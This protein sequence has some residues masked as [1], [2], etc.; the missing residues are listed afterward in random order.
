[1]GP[2]ETLAATLHYVSESSG[3]AAET[4][5]QRT[6]FELRGRRGQL[7]GLLVLLHSG[8]RD[9][10]SPEFQAFTQRLTG[11]LA[12]AIETRQLIQAQRQLFD[13]VI[14]VLADA[15]DAKSAYT[16]GHCERVPK[17]SIM[18]ADRLA[19]ETS[20]PY[21]DFKL[22]E[23]D[24]YAFHLAAWL[25]DCG[26]VTSPEHIVDKA[27]KLE[28][29]YDRIHEI[30]MRF[31]V[32]WRDAEI[33]YLRALLAG[34]D[35]EA[36]ADARNERQAQLH[37]DFHFVATCNLGGEFLGDE[38]I[39]RLQQISKTTWLRQFDDSLG[40]GIEARR[41]LE[42]V[43]GPSPALPVQEPLLADRPEHRLPWH[44]RKPPVERNDPRNTLGFDM[45][46]PA[47]RQNLGELHNLSIRRGTLT[48]EDRFAIND[49]IVQTLTM[50]K[51]LPWPAHLSRVPDIAANHHEKMDGSGYPRRIPA[52]TLPVTDRIMALADVF[53]ALTAADRPYKP[54]KRLS[55]SL[56]IMAF[57]G[58]EGHL[59][60]E[61]YLYFLHSRT[62]QSYAQRFLRPEQID[63]VDVEALARIVKD[64]EVCA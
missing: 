59:D 19:A 44:E 43:R 23:D 15:I 47:H 51:K 38:T 6:D 40:L 22:D 28:T 26:K 14:R 62:W 50:L 9:H 54:A 37:D 12:V 61:L 34:H 60:G 55:E 33:D 10:A 64:G 13:A 16:G 46:L 24:R 35:A 42:R 8:D 39:A 48:D 30:R 18:L 52:A 3:P 58:K 20:G 31:E 27:T 1:V 56:H 32:L 11:M 2:Q 5:Y 17:L 41:H 45:T 4:A 36:A 57:M 49:H 7:E 25:H 29:I 21:A 53:E 63:D